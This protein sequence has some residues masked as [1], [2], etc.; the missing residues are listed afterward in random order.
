MATYLKKAIKTAQSDESKIRETVAGIL[1]DIEKRG[2]AAVS[3]LAAKF[4]NWTEDVILTEEKKQ[5]LIATV[6]QA[7]KDDFKFAYEQVSS[8]AAKQRESMQEFETEITPG[9]VLGQRLVPVQCAGCYIPGGRFAHASSS[10][11]S[12]ATAKAAGR[13]LE[14]V[15]VVVGTDEDPQDMDA[16]IEMLQGAGANVDTSNDFVVRYAGELVST[17]AQPAAEADTAAFTEVDLDMLKQPLAGINAGLE[18]FADSI[19]EQDAAAIHVDWRPPAG[20][21]EKLMAIL[22]RMKG[23]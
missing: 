14:V 13:H 1:D 7:V 21:N 16:Q 3:E 6:P 12:A 11:M 15:A 19:K 2:E 8:F 22:E 9:V 20:G 18:S 10:I 17:L 5:E 4:D 23:K